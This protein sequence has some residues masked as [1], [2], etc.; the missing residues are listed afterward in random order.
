MPPK[1]LFTHVPE[2]MAPAGDWDCARAA[3]ENGADAVYFGLQGGFNAR[4]RAA[5]FSQAELPELM[6]FLRTRGVK[7]YL[8]LNTLV[9]RDELDEAERTARVA[10]E[11]GID[12]VLVQDLG[13]L[14]LLGRLCP[15]L[16]LHASTQMTLS[17][18]EC[19]REVESLGVRRVVLP[20]ELSI[21]QIAAIRRQTAVELEA[22]V[23]GALCISYSGQ[24]LASLSM[25]GR[26]ANRGQCAQPCRLPYE[27]I[28]SRVGQ[29]QRSPTK[30]NE[31]D[32]EECGGAALRLTHPTVHDARDKPY[33][34]SPHDLAAY[35]RLPELI[36]AGVSALKI[37]GRLK[38]A[39]YVASV[40]RHYRAALDAAWI[41][42]C[43]TNSNSRRLTA[44]GRGVEIADELRRA[45]PAGYSI[46]EMELTF[47]RGFCHGWLDGPDHRTL[48]SGVGSAKRGVLLGLVR[49]VRGERILVELAGPVMRGDGV[50]FE[51]DRSQAAEQ[52]GRVYEVF[53][54][55]RSI[56]EEVAAGL[57]E[58]AFRYG[59]IDRA[60]IRLGQE[61]WKTDDPRAARRLRQSYDSGHW[62]RR[63]PLDLVVDASVGS[64]L[65]VIVTATT[66]AVGR[67]ESPQPLP[68][69][70]KHPLTAETLR[71]QFGRLGKTP[72]ELR[73]LEAKLDGRAMIP[74][75]EL[76]KLRHEMIRQLDAAAAQPPQ[77]AVLDSS[78]L[79]AL[80]VQIRVEGESG[81]GREGEKSLKT[82]ISQSPSLLVSPSP[83]L[84]LSPFPPLTL[85][86]LCRSMEQIEAALD[87]GASSLIADFRESH[88]YGNAIRAAHLGGAAIVLAT[89][90]IHKP[91]ESGVFQQLAEQKP[92]GMLVRNLAGL[93]FCRGKGLPAVA[94]FSLN[95][96]NDL[97]VEWLHAQGARRVTAAYDLN[98]E[99]LL[100]LTTAIPPEWLEVVVQRHTPMFHSEYCVFCGMLSSGKNNADCGQPCQRH[101][102]R[103]RDRL[104]VEHILQADDQCRNTLFHAEAESLLKI[105][106]SLQ[107]RGVRHF[108]VELLAESSL[109]EVRRTLTPYQR[110]CKGWH[111][112]KGRGESPRSALEPTTP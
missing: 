109:T 1:P 68:E 67:L 34:L 24:C 10:V 35:D 41:A 94:D 77:R 30:G 15:E 39:E 86:V 78:A 102:I 51:G 46:A 101:K 57:V 59:S 4:A 103:L 93:A 60:A 112:L 7:G 18:A 3:V 42:A 71:E 50:V 88:R 45:L 69:A 96:V 48:V 32:V 52:G 27:W 62:Q 99:R 11:A 25:G 105:M 55:G 61:V 23:H 37:E 44:A 83:P 75:S 73:G 8:T 85:H 91:G 72:Y 74:L 79:A 84:P 95:A 110:R 12:A 76:G 31:N 28:S 104:G 92:D 70:T 87:C 64:P 17:S 20:R 97:S 63:V 107:E 53:Q 16:P 26:S 81:R 13:L 111:A 108:R 43:D 56:E 5:N 40:T 54:N 22:F 98:A 14:R 82:F 29:A 47:S 2:L 19:I 33:P 80:R 58:L 106:P 6:T 100:D 66:G 65:V 90:R 49:G 36:A 89:P 21:D 38:P 9:F